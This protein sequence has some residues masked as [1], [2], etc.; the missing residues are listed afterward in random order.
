MLNWCFKEQPQFH[1]P[2]PTPTPNQDCFFSSTAQTNSVDSVFSPRLDLQP[3]KD[4]HA[5]NGLPTPMSDVVFPETPHSQ[6]SVTSD[7]EPLSKAF[8]AIDNWR[9]EGNLKKPQNTLANSLVASI[10]DVRHWRKRRRSESSINSIVAA[11]TTGHHLKKVAHN[12]IERRYRNNINDRIQDL[13]DVLQTDAKNKAAILHEAT[14]HIHHLQHLNAAAERENHVL[15]QIL[16]HMP[17]GTRVLSRFKCHKKALQEAEQHRA[18][19]ERKQL[20]EHDK[21]ERQKVLS[22]RAAQRAALAQVIPKPAR[23]PYRRKKQ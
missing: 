10:T 19:L 5:N 17:G 16:T 13:K 9:H 21:I 7:D 22:E 11:V 12:A 18:T 3:S 1:T 23:R 4:T 6:T 14:E 8:A 20:E 15:Q 2:I